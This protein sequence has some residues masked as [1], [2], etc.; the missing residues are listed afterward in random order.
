MSISGTEVDAEERSET[1][2]KREVKANPCIG[3][4]GR[5]EEDPSQ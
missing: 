1:T 5:R 4:L 3:D 2:D